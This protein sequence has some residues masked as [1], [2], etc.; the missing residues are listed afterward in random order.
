MRALIQDF[1]DART[2]YSAHF[3]DKVSR[4][5]FAAELV[6]VNTNIPQDRRACGGD[7]P[8]A[9]PGRV[10]AASVNVQYAVCCGMLCLSVSSSPS[11]S[12]GIPNVRGSSEMS[13]FKAGGMSHSVSSDWQRAV[14]VA[15]R[16]QWS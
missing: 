14:I 11:A 16:V 12:H 3:Q 9:A 6:H 13:S 7:H 1:V 10:E 4:I 15:P 5:E 8:E 2:A